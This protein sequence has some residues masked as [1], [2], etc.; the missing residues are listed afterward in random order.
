MAAKFN[1]VAQLLLQGPKN[2]TSVVKD[3][4]SQL[5]NVQANVSVKIDPRAT[6]QIAS[7]NKKALQTRLEKQSELYL[8]NLAKQASL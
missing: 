6:R 7:L 8:A 3:I 5:S 4:K 2:L 1:I